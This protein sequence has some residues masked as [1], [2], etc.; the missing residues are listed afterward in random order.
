VTRYVT[1]RPRADYDDDL[2]ARAVLPTIVVTEPA[3]D[4]HDTGL[5]DA[6]GD[7]IFRMRSPIGFVTA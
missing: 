7:P 4:F 5:L 1:R 3:D 6:S 2:E